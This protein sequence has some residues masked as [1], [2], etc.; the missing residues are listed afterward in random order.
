M[1]QT[2]LPCHALL[3]ASEPGDILQ[4][5]SGQKHL[6][7]AFITSGKR[8]EHYI[9]AMKPRLFIFL[10]TLLLSANSTAL[11]FFFFFL[12]F[13][14]LEKIKVDYLAL[15]YFSNAGIVV[16]ASFD[17]PKCW[18]WRCTMTV[19]Q[20][21]LGKKWWRPPLNN[22]PPVNRLNT[23]LMRIKDLGERNSTQAQH[24]HDPDW[25]SFLHIIYADKIIKRSRYIFCVTVRTL[26]AKNAESCIISEGDLK[27][28]GLL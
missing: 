19:R 4:P 9:E 2:F 20:R 17:F 23:S 13:L 21:W 3:S 11:F 7:S 18:Y 25:F 5:F 24:Q 14:G 6:R 12:L 28:S 26:Q 16:A 8:I 27:V 1:T 15:L 10:C 22:P